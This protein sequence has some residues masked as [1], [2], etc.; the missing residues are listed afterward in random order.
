MSGF[1]IVIY[2][3]FHIQ[4]YIYFLYIYIAECI[5]PIRAQVVHHSAAD[6]EAY[7]S[8]RIPS[9]TKDGSSDLL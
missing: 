2:F 5:E 4:D 3:D 6:M 9:Q 1:I 8:Y 7:N